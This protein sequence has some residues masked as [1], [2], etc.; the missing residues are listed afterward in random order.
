MEIRF[1]EKNFQI[2]DACPIDAPRNRNLRRHLREHGVESLLA[3]KKLSQFSGCV[4]DDLLEAGAVIVESTVEARKEIPSSESVD[5][6]EAKLADSIEL[7]P[8]KERTPDPS[9]SSLK[10]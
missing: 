1:E 5:H 6:R 3:S 2:P 8:A 4:L 9:R 7:N 10:S